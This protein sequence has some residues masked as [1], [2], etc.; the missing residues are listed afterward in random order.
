MEHGTSNYFHF[1]VFCLL[2]VFS[3][4]IQSKHSKHY[5]I[6]IFTISFPASLGRQYTY[7][8]RVKVFVVWKK[9]Y[10][11]INTLA[12][13][14]SCFLSVIVKIYLFTNFL[15]ISFKTLN[16]SLSESI[17]I[18][19]GKSFRRFWFVHINRIQNNFKFKL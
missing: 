17:F 2:F 14:I 1:L 13:V 6:C 18:S 12:M 19:D 3:I 7:V 15:F 9:L 4:C 5:Q 16:K 8:F 10:R 11:N